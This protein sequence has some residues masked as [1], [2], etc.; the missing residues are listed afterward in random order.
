MDML[1]KTL[2][3][4]SATRKSQL[5]IA[6]SSVTIPSPHHLVQNKMFVAIANSNELQN[7]DNNADAYDGE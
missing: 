4:S 1:I 7:H 3:Y 6:K 2:Y 5:A